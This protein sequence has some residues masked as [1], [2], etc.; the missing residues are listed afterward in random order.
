[1]E[2]NFVSGLTAQNGTETIKTLIASYQVPQ[3][4]T[5]LIEVGCQIVSAGMTTLE[6]ISCILEIESQD[7]TAWTPQQ[8]ASDV[9]LPL[10]SGVVNLSSKVHDVNIPVTPGTHLDFSTTFNVALTITPS[11]RIFGKFA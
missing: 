4:V 10:A 2:K 3:G 5:K 8:L 11:I 9:I 1:M 7:A 6:S